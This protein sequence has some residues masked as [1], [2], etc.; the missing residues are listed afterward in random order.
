MMIL[1][2]ILFMGGV[3][4]SVVKEYPGLKYLD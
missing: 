4:I 1:L 2:E 3:V